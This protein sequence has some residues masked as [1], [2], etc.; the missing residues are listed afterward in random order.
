VITDTHPL[1][2]PSPI[3]PPAPPTAHGALAQVT[4]LLTRHRQLTV[5][6]ARREISERYTGQLF[7]VFWAVGHPLILMLVYVYIFGVV[8]KVKIGGTSSMPLD[9][10]TYLLAGLIPWLSFQDSM[11]KATTVIVG[12]ANL[13]KQVVFPLEVLPAKGVL[14]TLVTELVFVGLLIGYVLIR[15]HTLPLIYVLIPALIVLQGLAMMG[16][17]Y[18]LSA[19]GVYLRDTK[20]FVQIFLVIG[21]YLVPTFYLPSFVPAQFRVLLYLNPF[22]YM[23]W[24]FQDVLYFGRFAHPWAWPVF[25]ATSVAVLSFGFGVFNRLR[26]MFGNVL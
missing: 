20:D 11:A 2:P 10:T 12:N 1:A 23:V 3:A 9:Y 5:E 19:I 16:V 6:M 14:A 17:S 25:V 8:F 15:Y 18:A 4:A 13:V 22:S 26:T 21:V 24:C 7:G